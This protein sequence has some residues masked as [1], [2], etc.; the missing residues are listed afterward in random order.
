MAGASGMLY[1]QEESEV[2][3]YLEINDTKKAYPTGLSNL[4][5]NTNC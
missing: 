5:R 2:S 1:N 4:E 3:L